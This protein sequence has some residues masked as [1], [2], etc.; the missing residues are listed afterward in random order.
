MWEE[1]IIRTRQIT[2]SELIQVEKQD[3]WP[4]ARGR[5]ALQVEREREK[6]RERERNRRVTIVGII[7][8]AYL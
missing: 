1:E 3:G 6:E 8:T 5:R 2:A 4:S 7:I